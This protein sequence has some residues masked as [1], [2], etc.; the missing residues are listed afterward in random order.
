MLYY[1]NSSDS[2]FY[3]NTKADGGMTVDLKLRAESNES[4]SYEASVDLSEGGYY[5]SLTVDA[6]ALENAL[7]SNTTYDLNIYS[8]GLLVYSDKLGYKLTTSESGFTTVQNT[9]NDDF[10]IL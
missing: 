8:G 5:Q 10:V 3:V 2:T 1:S 7:K 9:T 4:Y 6:T